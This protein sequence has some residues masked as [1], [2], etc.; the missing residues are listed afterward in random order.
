VGAIERFFLIE[1]NWVFEYENTR[2][3]RS[4]TELYQGAILSI[5]CNI[6][7]CYLQNEFLHLRQKYTYHI[8]QVT[9]AIS[10]HWQL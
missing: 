7:L 10:D 8:L 4:S 5:V 1:S 3:G 9:A 2:G 6:F